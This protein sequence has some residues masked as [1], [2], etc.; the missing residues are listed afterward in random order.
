M[1]AGMSQHPPFTILLWDIRG[2]SM[3]THGTP[4]DI[5]G[6]HMAQHGTSWAADLGT[7]STGPGDGWPGSTIGPGMLGLW[8]D[9]GST[10]EWRF[11]AKHLVELC[12]FYFDESMPIWHG[13]TVCYSFSS[14]RT[15]EIISEKARLIQWNVNV[16][17][18]WKKVRD[19]NGEIL[20][21]SE[22]RPLLAECFN[23]EMVSEPNIYW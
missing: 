1:N 10:A 15:E 16:A 7:H 20:L 23:A 5:H 4:W 22:L 6:I 19:G 21:A 12:R 9:W 3:A 18:H 11:L 17:N 8:S 14:S 2:I 13:M